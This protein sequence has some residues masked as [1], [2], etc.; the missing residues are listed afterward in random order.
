MKLKTLTLHHYRNYASLVFQAGDGITIFTGANAQGKTNLVESVYLCCTGRSHRTSRDKELIA[1][2]SDQAYVRADTVHRDGTHCVELGLSRTGRKSLRV[3]GL[4]ARRLGELMGHVN[5]VIFSP[6]DL[7]LVRGGPAGRRRFMDMEI[8][9]GNALYFYELQ[10]YQKAL[11][12]RNALLRGLRARPADA[13]TLDIWDEQLATSGARIALRRREFFGQLERYAVELHAH[14]SGGG[15]LALRYHASVDEADEAGA[16]RELLDKLKKN[17]DTDIRLLA[18]SVGPH[19]DDLSFLVDGEDLRGFGSQGQQ[20]TV[21]VALKMAE[22]SIME[23][24]T[25]EMPILI[26]DDV[27]SELDEYRRRSLL[28]AV[29]DAQTLITCVRVEAELAALDVPTTTYCI[30]HGTLKKRRG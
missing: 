19:R 10:A 22:L 3:N 29:G 30:E 4:P 12:Q 21:A 25:G 23:Q 15:Q 2:D 17:R 13:D 6:E 9:Q 26:L 11:T 28:T 16:A 7:L 14:I 1:R 5:A 8:S 20:R 27:L 18:T 24:V